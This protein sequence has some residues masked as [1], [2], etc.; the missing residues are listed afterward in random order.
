MFGGDGGQ[1]G[2]RIP[3]DIFASL[4]KIASGE[5]I[6]MYL[7]DSGQE[8]MY[9]ATCKS[10]QWDKNFGKKKSPKPSMT[11]KY[12]NDNEYLCW[13][14]FS[15]I[16][17]IDRPNEA[18]HDFTYVRVDEFFENHPSVFGD[19]YGKQIASLR[20]L[21]EQER[22]I[23]FIRPHRKTDPTHEILLLDGQRL[24]PTHFQDLFQ[25][26][27]S[28]K[29]LWISDLHCSTDHHRFPIEEPMEGQ[30]N[31][32]T[33]LRKAL[34]KHKIEDLGGVIVS[35]DITWHADPA[36][37]NMAE[38]IFRWIRSLNKLKII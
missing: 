18:I 32:T 15:N 29:F 1:K 19:Y 5:T 16:A 33:A 3:P 13:F 23:W 7:F 2:E 8:K 36:E 25:E 11:P 20:E 4:D 10:I 37:F 38:H 34:E 27:N 14:K 24:Q 6:K 28:S 26:K 21:R 22:S 30:D 17:E 12:Y 35:G 31:F 9:R